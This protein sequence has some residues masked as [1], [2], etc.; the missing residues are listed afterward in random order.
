MIDFHAH[1]NRSYCAARDLT[2]EDYAQQIALRPELSAVCMTDHGMAIYFPEEVVWN[3]EFI[4]DSSVLDKYLARGNA[5]M[6][7]YLMELAKYQNRGIHPG[8]EVEMAVDGRLI[9]DPAFRKELKVLI[10]S[11][12]ALPVPKSATSRDCPGIISYWKEH[13]T[14]L[15]DSG[16]DILGHPFRWLNRQVDVPDETVVW[17]VQTAKAAGVALEINAHSLHHE[18]QLDIAML[19]EAASS[20]AKIAFGSDSHQLSEIGNF[21]YLD[22]I[23]AAAGVKLSE[24]KLLDIS[25]KRR[26]TVIDKF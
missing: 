15:L 2:F 1:S 26:K 3:W 17:T 25:R 21:P 22:Q 12:H 18:T 16:I 10:G 7:Q 14:R 19:K 24:L 23:A 20:G 13:N 8:L 9:Y 11:V 4:S 6:E 5:L